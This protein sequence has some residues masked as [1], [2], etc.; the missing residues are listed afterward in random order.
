MTQKSLAQRLLEACEAHKSLLCVGLDPDPARM[1]I[2]DVFEFNRRIIDA[3]CDL[4]C[5]YKPNLAFYE[6]L[7]L[8][9][10]EALKQTVDYIRQAAPGVIIIGDGK[11]GD[12]GHT[13]AAYARA[14][15]EVWGF[16]ATTVNAFGGGDTVEPFLAYP[17]R[18]VFV[19]CR[20][21]NPG[22]RDFQDLPTDLEGVLR[23]LYMQLAIKALHWHD[24]GDLG[25]VVG[26]T[27][28]DELKKVRAF[29]PH[30]PVLIPGVGAQAG[31]LALSVRYGTDKHGRMAIIAASRQVLYASKGEDFPQ[32]ARKV[33]AALRDEIN[34][35]LEEEGKGWR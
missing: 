1:P 30:L 16:D 17:G 29:C 12:I 24:K 6:A 19:W 18:G 20:S 5:S 23:P 15:F 14:M 11:R 34:Q 32:V 21:S 28:P 22:A 9:G 10:L 4:V 25:L 27:Y 33:A 3:T 2:P 35:V 31:H 26:A 7:G 13:A 8:P